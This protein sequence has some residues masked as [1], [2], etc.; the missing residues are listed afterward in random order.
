MKNIK[1]YIVSPSRLLIEFDN[2]SIEL[3][4]ELTTTPVFYADTSSFKNWKHPFE[5][6]EISESE[7]KEIIDFITKDSSSQGNTKIIF[8]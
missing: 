2:K 6:T 1:Y 4:G 8:D 7:K 3:T 5:K